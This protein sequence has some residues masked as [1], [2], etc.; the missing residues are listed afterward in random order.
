LICSFSIP[1]EID[2]RA[3]ASL[4][5][6]DVLAVH[7][8]TADLGGQP[9]GVKHQF[10]PDRHPSGEGGAGD[11]RAEPLHG[12]HPVD[13]QTKRPEF[14]VEIHGRHLGVE[15]PNDLI[16]PLAAEGIHRN[17]RRVFQ[18]AAGEELAD[19]LADPCRAIR[20][21]PCPFLV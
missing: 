10:V 2:G 17:N 15:Q 21:R 4:D 6:L 12:E 5:Q 8:D 1:L 14:L 7:L 20:S 19:L 18:K 3:V 9:A 13:R 11:H 16:D